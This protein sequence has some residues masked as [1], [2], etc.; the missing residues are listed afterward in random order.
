MSKNGDIVA[1]CRIKPDSLQIK[2]NLI[3]SEKGKQLVGG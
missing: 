2:R 3:R 1:K